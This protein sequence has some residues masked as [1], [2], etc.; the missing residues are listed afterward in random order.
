MNKLYYKN[1]I[2]KMASDYIPPYWNDEFSYDATE[3]DID[4]HISDELKEKRK[5]FTPLRNFNGSVLLKN[6]KTNKLHEW[7]SDEPNKIRELKKEDLLNY[8]DFNKLMEARKARPNIKRP[9]TKRMGMIGAAIGATALPLGAAYL[10]K[11]NIP[12]IKTPTALGALGLAATGGL[13]GGSV[14]GFG[15][16]I[17]NMRELKA[18]KEIYGKKLEEKKD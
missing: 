11:H 5:E 7:H 15:E 13:L 8:D 12:N 17:N 16:D 4:D 9:N 14:A 6:K 3:E 10:S 1:Q 2:E 18:L